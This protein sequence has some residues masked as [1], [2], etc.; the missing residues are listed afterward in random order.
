MSSR[1]SPRSRPT[2]CEGGTRYYDGQFDD[3]R[4]AT[5]LATT[6][7]E[8]GG[9]LANYT[10]VVGLLKD[11]DGAMQGVVARELESGDELEVRGKVVVNATGP[12]ADGVRKL[13]RP[14][15]PPIIAPSQ[16]VH[17]VLDRSF[18]SGTSAIMVPHTDDGRV[19]FAIPWHDVAVVGTTDTPIEEIELEP[20]PLRSEVE[21]ILDTANRYLSRP[22]AMEDIRSI[23]AG[24][25]PLVKAGE[26][27]DTAA[28]S[29]DHTILIDPNSGLMT[30]AGG[31]WTTY[32]KMAEDVIDQAI[33]LG[34]LE[35]RECVTRQL[36][37][38]G[39]H[40]NTER[41]GRLDFYG[42][43]APEV[44]R[45]IEADE[46]SDTRLHPRLEITYGEV[47]WACRREMARTVDD[48]LA[49]RTRSLLF[50]A[51]A[52]VEAAPQVA[53]IM[54]EELGM[55]S[56]WIAQQAA[57][58]GAIAANYVISP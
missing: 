18:I 17:I 41:F 32:R 52:A 53:T 13:D 56:A 2:G 47:R 19:M 15:G 20:R 42:S 51:E 3:A 58:F 43:D 5:N 54:A 36:P 29:R 57:E 34:D 37:I 45:M 9:T 10:Q 25:R 49:R 7:F 27:E 30:V 35:P 38:H 39:Y 4:L 40:R 24:I 1:R 48:V 31:K 33:T 21:F 16:G 46:H 22:A 23:F 14:D 50:D 6:A 55:D 11:A 8:Q 28:L 12:F 44:Q 26:G